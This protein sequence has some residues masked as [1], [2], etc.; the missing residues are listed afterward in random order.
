MRHRS[1]GPLLGA[2]PRRG[3]ALLLVVIV[4]LMLLG[5]AAATLSTT[6]IRSRAAVSDRLRLEA[7]DAAEAGVALA[8]E[9][10]VE[11]EGR[12][13][14]PD[15]EGS[16]TAAPL[17]ITLAGGAVTVETEELGSN[18]EDDDG[19]GE[20]DEEDEAAVVRIRATGAL[21]AGGEPFARTVEVHAVPEDHEA[22]YKAVFVGNETDAEGYVLHF[23][24][25][26]GSPRAPANDRT[27][28]ARDGSW[29]TSRH[30]NNADYVDGDVY[31]NGTVQVT[32][33][34]NVFGDLDATGAVVGRPVSGESTEGVRRI[35]PPDLA[36][37]DY[38]AQ[39]DRV[40]AEGTPLPA[41]MRAE[42]DPSYYGGVLGEATAHDRPYFHLGDE[43]G[44][45]ALQE[46]DS[47]T[48]V[49][50]KGNLWIHSVRSLTVNFPRDP[51]VHVTLVV[52][53]NVYVADD[54]EYDGEDDGLL[55]I[56][57][58]PDG[59]ESYT[60]LNRNY[61]WDEGEPVLNDDGDG[62]YD[63]P[64]EGS[65]NIFFGDPRFGTG[66]V[67][68]GYLYA[69]NNVY[70]VNEGTEG[71][72]GS[73]ERVWGVQ[74]FLSAGNLIDLGDR[75]GGRNYENFRVRYDTRFRRLDFK[76]VPGPVGGG[77]LSTLTVVAWRELP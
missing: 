64:V 42:E 7:L 70:L 49:V 54:V 77:G 27:P 17:V 12:A 68:D 60:D 29:D 23:G 9:R 48:L 24:P 16:I 35:T 67:T 22:F 20:V 26:N 52:E 28:P 41:W 39:A 65:G 72:Y 33:Q 43:S 76:G 40:V 74:G 2:D 50:V 51:D 69:Q 36:A 30:T 15:D 57:K 62:R 53:G 19:D 56:A 55:I 37:Q 45:I 32:G 18:G 8:L 47:G 58:S 73:D 4:T 25:G 66:G 6:S 34:S 38:A 10:I 11:S 21:E 1:R 46:S 31:V 59:E 5:L 75:R 71:R 61:R 13:L 44:D 3:T 63:G 14:D